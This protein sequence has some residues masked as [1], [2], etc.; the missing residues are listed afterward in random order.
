LT[1]AQDSIPNKI[2]LGFGASNFHILDEHATFLI[3]R[4][5]GIA[6]SVAYSHTGS[7]VMHQIRGAF[8]YNNL[9]ASVDNFKTELIGGQFRYACLISAGNGNDLLSVGL[10]LSSVFFKTDYYFNSQVYWL[11]AI[12]SWNWCHSVDI[13]LQ[14][15]KEWGKNR[16]GFMVFVPLVSN[17]SRPKYSSSGDY[18]YEKNDWDVKTFGRTVFVSKNP[19]VNVHLNYSRNLSRRVI[20]DAGY[21]FYYSYNENPELIRFYMNNFRL[22][23]SYSF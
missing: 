15:N 8:Y 11:K 6:P 4:G 21:E 14:L 10:S 12:E 1:S 23:I 19:C 9:K 2:S 20:L 13:A 5:T 7:K 16:I 3:F 22:G 17:I 18:N